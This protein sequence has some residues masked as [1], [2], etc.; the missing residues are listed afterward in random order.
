MMQLDARTLALA[1]QQL[2]QHLQAQQ[3]ATPS[4]VQPGASQVNALPTTPSAS[5][6][7]KATK[8]SLD[9]ASQ[10]GAGKK[11]LKTE[12]WFGGQF[13]IKVLILRLVTKMAVAVVDI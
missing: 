11:P 8:R 1:Q 4:F 9:E 6:L 12:V 13:H 7:S 2:Q 5:L 3:G 10:G